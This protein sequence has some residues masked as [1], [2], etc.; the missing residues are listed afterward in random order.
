MVAL[1]VVS[2]ALAVWVYRLKTREPIAQDAPVLSATRGAWELTVTGGWIKTK[3]RLVAVIAAAVLVG[4]SAILLLT[5][6][7]LAW[8][9]S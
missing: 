6:W 1:F 3:G 7:L 9:L 8:A 5:G 2:L 4:Y